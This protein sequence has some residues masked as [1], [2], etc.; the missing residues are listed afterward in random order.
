MSSKMHTVNLRELKSELEWHL[1][2]LRRQ[3]ATL[4]YLTGRYSEGVL[5]EKGLS[6]S[7]IREIRNDPVLLKQFA[8]LEEFEHRIQ[9]M[10]ARGF[11]TQKIYPS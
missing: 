11:Q 5:K 8:E 3:R 9:E 1:A 10:E 2:W 4:S 7:R 6:D